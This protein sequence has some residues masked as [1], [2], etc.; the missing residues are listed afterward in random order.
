MRWD[1]IHFNWGLWD[2]C[3]R[4][5]EVKTH[6][7]RDKLHGSLTSSPEIYASN[8]KRAV[9]LLQDTGAKLIWCNTTPV[10]QKEAGRFQGDEISYNLIAKAIMRERGVA[11]H[12]L[13]AHCLE[14]GPGYFD[15]PGNVHFTPQ[16]Y[17]LLG[18]KV[19]TEI[20]KWLS[21]RTR[22]AIEVGPNAPPVDNRDNRSSFR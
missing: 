21:A 8:L 15:G 14:M 4:N 5:P 20:Q 1:V 6:G 16:G 2:I 12:D 19:A 17:V 3:Y 13:H 22:L 7:H 9:D 11:V 18:K 10:P